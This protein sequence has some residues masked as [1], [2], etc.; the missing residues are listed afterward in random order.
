MRLQSDPTIIYGIYRRRGQ[1]G[2]SNRSSS[3]TSTKETPF[4]T[5]MIKGLPPTPIANPGRAALEAVANPSK[6]GLPLL[7]R[8]RHRRP[9]LRR[10]AGRAQRRTCAAGASSKRRA[11][12]Q[13]AANGS[14]AEA[15]ANGSQYANGAGGD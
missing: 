1:A 3:R 8:R 4:N 5:Y 15:D 6:H 2:R 11:A 12:K 13:K 7:R 14:E 10:D 9:R